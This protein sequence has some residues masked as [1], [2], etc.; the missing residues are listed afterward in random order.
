MM[1]T[2]SYHTNSI[3]YPPELRHVYHDHENCPNGRRILPGHR[4]KGTGGKPHCKE[5][6]KLG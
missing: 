4:Q 1:K 3:E 5:C 6:I 2:A